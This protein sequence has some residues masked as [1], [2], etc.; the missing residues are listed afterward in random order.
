MLDPKTTALVLIDLQK[1]IVGNPQLAP[2]PGSAVVAAA[3]K[4]AE[5]FRAAGALVVL[6][7]VAFAKDYSDMPNR[8]VDQPMQLP[9]KGLPDEWS[10]FVD[11]LKMPADLVVLKRQWGAFYGTDLDLQLRRRGIRSIVLGG[12]STNFGV[13]STARAAWEH[14][15]AVQIVEDLCA[16]PS[17]EAHEFAIRTIFPRI[18]HVIQSGDIEFAKNG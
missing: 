10:A 2:R 1:G 15:Y 14:G 12:I 17:T 6:V 8:D 3:H 9:A 11:G 13:E 16:G 18:S 5:Q 4:T 7:H